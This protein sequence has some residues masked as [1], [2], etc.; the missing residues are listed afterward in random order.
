MIKR[1]LAA[2]LFTAMVS[3]AA[4]AAETPRNADECNAL[5]KNTVALFDNKTLSDQDENQLEQLF[6]TL[7]TQCSSNSYDEAARTAEEIERLV[8][9]A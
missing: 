9:D 2:S 7:D 3:G 6:D 8:P 1:M 4:I 5:V